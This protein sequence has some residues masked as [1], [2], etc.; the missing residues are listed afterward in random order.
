MSSKKVK[1][2]PL[3]WPW[4]LKEL[5]KPVT[6]PEEKV[7]MISGRNQPDACFEKEF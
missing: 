3:L 1:S 6:G 5:T 4:C 7:L 2:V